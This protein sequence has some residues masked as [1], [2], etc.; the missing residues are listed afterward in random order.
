MTAI[1]RHQTLTPRQMRRVILESPYAGD[2]ADNVAYA[3]ACVR[4]ALLR[5]EAPLA[6]HLLYT[7]PAVLD[8]N[9][10]R[11]RAHGINAGHAWLHLADAV[12]VYVDRGIS[13][14]MAAGIRMAEFIGVPIEYRRGITS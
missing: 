5:G 2:V 9:N 3:R 7:Q 12:V 14:G 10:G 6:S 11:E 13:E 8:D 4:D 1:P